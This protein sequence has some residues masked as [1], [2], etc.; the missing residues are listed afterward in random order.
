MPRKPKVVL[1]GEK[2]KVVDGGSTV[3]GHAIVTAK[4]TNNFYLVQYLTGN[5]AHLPPQKVAVCRLT[6]KLSEVTP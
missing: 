3:N 5:R 2:W 1:V 4:I 6:E